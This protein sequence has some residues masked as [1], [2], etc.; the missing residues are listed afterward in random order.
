M[1]T[2]INPETKNIINNMDVQTVAENLYNAAAVYGLTAEKDKM[3]NE[4]NDAI[5]HIRAI[6]HND[7]NDEYWRTLIIA[8]ATA[9]RGGVKRDG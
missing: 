7:M 4:L 9:F 8:L 3:I 6:A 5:N 1:E 2:R